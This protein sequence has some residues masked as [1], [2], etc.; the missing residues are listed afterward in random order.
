ME[1]EADSGIAV[2]RSAVDQSGLHRLLARTREARLTLT[3]DDATQFTSPGFWG[4]LNRLGITQ[5]WTA[6]HHAE[7]N[8]HIERFHRAMK[9]DEFSPHCFT[10]ASLVHSSGDLSLRLRAPP[11]RLG[12][13]DQAGTLSVCLRIC[14]RVRRERLVLPSGWPIYAMA[15]GFFV[16]S[17]D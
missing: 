13:F 3:P 2:L 6:Y 4:T 14:V 11:P 7:G 12:H 5:R 8:I 9:E 15:D 17:W 1:G 10:S 16:H